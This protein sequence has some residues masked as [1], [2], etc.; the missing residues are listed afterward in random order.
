M[1]SI[2]NIGNCFET[3]KFAGDFF[4]TTVGKVER[5][6]RLLKG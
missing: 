2:T 5:I 4:S 1:Y 3:A 6:S